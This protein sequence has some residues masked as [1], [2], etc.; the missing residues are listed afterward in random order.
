[1]LGLG[2]AGVLKEQVTPIMQWE[3]KHTIFLTHNGKRKE[4]TRI[5]FNALK[6]AHY[7]P[8]LD[9]SDESLPKGEKWYITMLDAAN[10]CRVVIVVLSNDFFLNSKWPMIELNELATA[11]E[12]SNSNLKMSLLH[13]GITFEQFGFGKKK[14]L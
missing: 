8:F 7:S 10:Q 13:L 11:Q 6:S 12:L 14:W 2:E 9:A 5:L 4:F 3:P 1:M